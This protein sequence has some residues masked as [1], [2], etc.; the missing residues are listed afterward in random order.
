MT[1]G[2]DRGI[3]PSIFRRPEDGL[4]SL[5]VFAHSHSLMNLTPLVHIPA[6]F[7]LTRTAPIAAQI[8]VVPLPPAPI[9]PVGQ[10]PDRHPLLASAPW[11]AV[12]LFTVFLIL[13]LHKFFTSQSADRPSSGWSSWASGPQVQPV[14]DPKYWSLILQAER[15]SLQQAQPEHADERPGS[16]QSTSKDSAPPG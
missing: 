10:Q 2:V 1:N 14:R 11:L 3:S 6:L 13:A 16:E 9:R 4:L 15:D 8:P 7:P 5:R 12:G